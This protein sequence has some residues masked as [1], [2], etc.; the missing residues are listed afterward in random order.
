M[1]DPKKDPV[2]IQK[3]QIPDVVA[4]TERKDESEISGKDLEKVAGGGYYGYGGG[5]NYN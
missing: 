4:D 3:V 2:Q 1:S 5:G